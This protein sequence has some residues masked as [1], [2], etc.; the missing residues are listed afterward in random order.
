MINLIEIALKGQELMNKYPEYREGVSFVMKNISKT[1][2]GSIDECV[3]YLADKVY[4][5]TVNLTLPREYNI[6]VGAI[7]LYSKM[8]TVLMDIKHKQNN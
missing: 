7:A 8:I 1:Y 6:L 2:D 3:A 4:I 5:S